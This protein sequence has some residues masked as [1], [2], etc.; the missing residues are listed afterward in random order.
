[1]KLES[2]RRLEYLKHLQNTRTSETSK[3]R[4][5]SSCH[6]YAHP[7]I[8]S[9]ATKKNSHNMAMIPPTPWIQ[10]CFLAWTKELSGR[11]NID[12]A[13]EDP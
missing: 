7:T 5:K 12:S 4:P 6:M 1:M 11:R 9:R 10:E 13:R 2:R 8:Q 3:I